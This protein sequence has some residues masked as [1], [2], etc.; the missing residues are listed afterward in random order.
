[1]FA[2]LHLIF[3]HPP[4]FHRP[5]VFFFFFFF[6]FLLDFQHLFFHIHQVVNGVR[7]VTGDIVEYHIGVDAKKKGS[8]MAIDVTLV[9]RDSPEPV[10]SIHDDLP[11]AELAH[12]D[13]AARRTSAQL[14][15]SPPHLLLS[16]GPSSPLAANSSAS[17]SLGA[18]PS[19]PTSLVGA[20]QSMSDHGPRTHHSRSSSS[21]WGMPLPEKAHS[22][23]STTSTTTSST[24]TLSVLSNASGSSG[25]PNI[26]NDYALFGGGAYVGNGGGV[27]ATTQTHLGLSPLAS[28]PPSLLYIRDSAVKQMDSLVLVANTAMTQLEQLRRENTLLRAALVRH[29]IDPDSVLAGAPTSLVVDD[30]SGGAS[31]L[32]TATAPPSSILSTTGSQAGQQYSPPSLFSLSKSPGLF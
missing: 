30:P 28:T 16:G 29:R 22:H 27:A 12:I 5:N 31:V 25:L 23:N 4:F 20:T 3:L 6:F 24:N 32:R 21:S 13:A 8:L 2:R 19:P 7:L 17:S 18:T 10:S 15:N 14:A 11:A 9:H 1:L 26:G